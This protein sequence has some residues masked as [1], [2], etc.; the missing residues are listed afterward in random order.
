MVDKK[1]GLTKLTEDSAIITDNSCLIKHHCIIHQENLCVEALNM[2][3][4]VQIF[5]KAVNFI[6]CN[7]LNHHHFQ[8]FLRNMDVN[9]GNIIN[10]SEGKVAKSG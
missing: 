2:D 10:F 9:Y 4:V 1:E 7:G 3:N 5:I 6:K 8:E